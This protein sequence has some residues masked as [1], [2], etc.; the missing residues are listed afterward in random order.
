MADMR[1]A[2][3]HAQSRFPR[4]LPTE[5]GS[6]SET[7]TVVGS[8]QADLGAKLSEKPG[9]NGGA[10]EMPA[11]SNTGLLTCRRQALLLHELAADVH[12]IE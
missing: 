11:S 4:T 1:W 9:D 10:E 3:N 6:V 12:R 2:V 5:S 7:H 8:G